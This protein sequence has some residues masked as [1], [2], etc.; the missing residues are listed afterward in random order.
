MSI[1]L[2]NN[3]QE[4]WTRYRMLVQQGSMDYVTTV[5]EY[6]RYCKMLEG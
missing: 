3:R 2:P 1:A 4:K 6:I 5:R